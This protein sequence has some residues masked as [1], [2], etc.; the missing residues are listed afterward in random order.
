LVAN[1]SYRLTQSVA[2]A[3]PGTVCYTVFSNTKLDLAGHSVLGRIKRNGSAN[4][5]HVFNGIV[6]CTW[7]D[8]GGD[9][10]CVNFS[11]TQTFT[12]E[13][14]VHHLTIFNS[15]QFSRGIHIDWAVTA[16]LLTPSIRIYNNTVGVGSQPLVSRS[17]AINVTANNHFIEGFNNDLTCAGDANAC[18]GFV[19]QNTAEC[20]LHHNRVNL[21]TNAT[22]A[23][24]RG[25]VWENSSQGEAWN[26][27]L[28]NN[29]N[30]SFRMRRSHNVRIHE[31]DFKVITDTRGFGALHL[32]DPDTG[33][34]DL[35]VLVD[36][37]NFELAGGNVIFLR[38]GFKAL[39]RGNFFTCVGGC[40]TSS[41]GSIRAPNPTGFRSEVTFENNQGIVL[42]AAPPQINVQAPAQVTV[43]NS[44]TAGGTGT[45]IIEPVCP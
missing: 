17:H 11:S 27:L 8:N 45:V 31:N 42:F 14:R 19:C 20:K 38:S 33:D 15:A 39:V 23:T 24:A 34:D 25:L 4:G 10:G 6:N 5:T 16:P 43:C 32:G 29:N 2:A 12:A 22:D 36:A 3:T 26:N 9:A 30:R 40:S 7:V 21:L 13:L 41:L 18:Q 28:N 37:N 44:G 1:T 35:N